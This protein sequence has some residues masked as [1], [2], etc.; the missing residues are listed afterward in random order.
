LSRTGSSKSSSQL[1]AA[2]RDINLTM[3]EEALEG[4]VAIGGAALPVLVEGLRNSDAAIAGGC[5][6]ALR[7]FKD[8]PSDLIN[9]LTTE[10]Q[11]NVPSPWAV[12]LVGHLPRDQFASAVAELQQQ[13]PEL[14]YAIS[15]L[16]SF[17]ESWISRNW[18]SSPHPQFPQ[19]EG[20]R[21]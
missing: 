15:L 18:D 17:V 21:T 4:L 9:A 16:W 14:H 1:V 10:L 5:A 7:R 13:R 3:R 12:W 2:F 19:S 11:S 6:E 8:V 20:G